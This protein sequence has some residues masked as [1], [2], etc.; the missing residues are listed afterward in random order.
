[1]LSKLNNEQN[2][3]DSIIENMTLL[4]SDVLSDSSL[5]ESK[6]NL[7]GVIKK[8]LVTNKDISPHLANTLAKTIL[9]SKMMEE[10]VERKKRYKKYSLLQKVYDHITNKTAQKLSSSSEDGGVDVSIIDL[11]TEVIKSLRGKAESV[12]D[13]QQTFNAIVDRLTKTSSNRNQL[14]IM[15]LASKIVQSNQNTEKRKEIINQFIE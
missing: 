14:D 12:D 5:L 2:T 3:K 1:M 11:T 10:I 7:N 9:F 15:K 6:N 8:V 4:C 13:V